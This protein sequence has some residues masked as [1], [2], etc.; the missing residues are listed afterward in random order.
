[1]SE[2]NIDAVEVAFWIRDNDRMLIS[3]AAMEQIG[4]K[5]EAAHAAGVAAERARVV[6]LLESLRI[7]HRIVDDDPWY[8]CPLAV[9]SD[10]T[11]A[12]AG[13]DTECNCAANKHNAKIDAYLWPEG[14]KL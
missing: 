10:G 4:N 13:Q 8:S 12:Y 5:I 7:S 9:W 3:A 2:L 6:A 1:M 14:K 11:K